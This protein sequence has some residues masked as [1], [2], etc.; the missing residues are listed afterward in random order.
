LV[1][2]RLPHQLV[3]G[4]FAALASLGAVQARELTD[5]SLSDLLTQEVTSVAKRPQDVK[6]APAAVFVIGREDIRRSGATTLPD[7]LRMVPGLEVAALSGG[8][9]AVSAR[10]F[11]GEISNKLLV[12]VDGRA[13]YLSALSTVPWDQ[14]MVPVEDIERIEVVRGPGAALWGANAVNGVI[15]V[16]TKH[17]VDTLGGKATA[18]ADTEDAGRIYLRQGF[19]VGASG[20]LRL[21]GVAHRDTGEGVFLGGLPVRD[22][23][24]GGQ[25]GFRYD[26]EP[27][28]RDAVTLQG[29]AQSGRFTPST[30]DVALV[31]IGD[32]TGRFSG[33][34]LLGRW[35]RTFGAGDSVALQA[36]FDRVDRVESGLPLERR[37]F[38]V[39]LSRQVRFGGRHD[40][41]W[42]LNYRRTENRFQNVG[43]YGMAD[44]NPNLYGGF[45]QDDVSLI[46]KRLTLSLGAKLEHNSQTGVEFQP[47]L[48]AI[49]TDAGDWSLWGAVSRAVRTPA[50]YETDLSVDPQPLPA[51]VVPGQPK[52]E[53]LTAFEAGWRGP[54]SRGVNLDVTAFYNRYSDLIALRGTPGIVHGGPGLIFAAANVTRARAYGVEARL[55]ARLRTW[56]TV[57]AAGS[58]LDVTTDPIRDTVVSVGS[59]GDGSSPKGQVSLRSMIDLGDTVDLDLWLRHVGALGDGLT[60]AYTNLDLRL[61]WRPT[62]TFEVSL[63]GTN[64]LGRKASEMRTDFNLRSDASAL[65]DRRLLVMLAA[66]Y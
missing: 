15:N 44:S 60:K 62:A 3:I 46:P 10:G 42:G 24:R 35:T 45:V 61:A 14:Q 37:V 57:S 51:L 12:L 19:R 49:W 47:S 66:R 50:T 39:D 26:A 11:N 41:V 43:A 58:W 29:D 8:K 21:Y 1:T 4:I 40:V 56:W 17:A 2:Y 52:A 27:A 18:Q 55:D 38:D 13:V 36:Y 59:L 5:L 33:Q 28:D 23:S 25:F 53:V 22:R 64:L 32:L 54:I 48:R 16:I 6:N 20:A 7:L 63:R 30:A 34:N 9:A 31:G 65:P